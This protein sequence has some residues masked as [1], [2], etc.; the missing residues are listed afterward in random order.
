MR[1]NMGGL[2]I[3]HFHGSRNPMVYRDWK[4]SLEAVRILSNLG[5]DKLAVYA[6]M[7]SVEKPRTRAGTLRWRS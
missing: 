2:K 3:E 5:D 7:L 6:W 4:A 1:P